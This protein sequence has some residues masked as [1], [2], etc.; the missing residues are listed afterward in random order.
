MA[1]GE[2]G[3]CFKY[4]VTILSTFFEGV[5]LTLLGYGGWLKNNAANYDKE[6]SLLFSIFTW[7]LLVEGS[8]MI[9]LG[10]GGIYIV[11]NQKRNCLKV[12]A[13]I[14]AVLALVDVVAGM[15][16]SIKC[17]DVRVK[18]ETGHRLVNLHSESSQCPGF[19]TDVPGEEPLVIGT[20]LGTA[21]LLIITSICSI[22]FLKQTDTEHMEFSAHFSAQ[23]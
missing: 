7:S 19:I 11:W 6:D 21:V 22:I 1:D 16:V 3:I 18:Q 17:K 14:L 2:G 9:I 8:V 20:L 15:F 5:G 10:T 23:K 12:F 13:I 4:I